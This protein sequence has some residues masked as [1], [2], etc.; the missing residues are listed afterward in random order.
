[1]NDWLSFVVQGDDLVGAA[2]E[3]EALKKKVKRYRTCASIAG[4]LLIIVIGI[5]I[6][7][8]ILGKQATG[9]GVQRRLLQIL[10]I[11]VLLWSVRLPLAA[12]VR[13]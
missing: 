1:M 12:A 8:A 10:R 7:I 4:V 11:L 5:W 6:G 13:A 2:H 3:Y 9:A